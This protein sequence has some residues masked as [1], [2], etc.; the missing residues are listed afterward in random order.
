MT[1]SKLRRFAMDAT[2]AVLFILGLVVGGVALG[3]V[4]ATVAMQIFPP[5]EQVTNLRR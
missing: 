2:K 3:H 5:H 4:T 1:G